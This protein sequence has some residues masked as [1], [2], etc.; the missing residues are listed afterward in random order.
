MLISERKLYLITCAKRTDYRLKLFLL[1][2]SS[3]EP[4]SES[5]KLLFKHNLFVC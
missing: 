2:S 4:L 1:S 5:S 3:L